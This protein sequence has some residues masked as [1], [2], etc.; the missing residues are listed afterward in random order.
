M[1]AFREMDG[2]RPSKTTGD[3]IKSCAII[4]PFYFSIKGIEQMKKWL[5]VIA[6][7]FVVSACANK[8]IYFNGAEGSHSGMKFDKDTHHWGV[9]Q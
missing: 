7:A 9:N 4:A 2:R 3:G 1:D 8:D 5:F 6:A